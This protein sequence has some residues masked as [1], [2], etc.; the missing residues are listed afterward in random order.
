M[1]FE[2]NLEQKVLHGEKSN[3]L[4][5]TKKMEISRDEF[6]RVY[7][8]NQNNFFTVLRE[9]IYMFHCVNGFI[10]QVSDWTMQSMYDTIKENPSY[11]GICYV[12]E[13]REELSTDSD[14]DRKKHVSIDLIYTK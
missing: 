13:E 5:T 7:K 6:I 8:E 9:T 2:M 14:Y 4:I 11:K 3:T 10:T 12:A 1:K